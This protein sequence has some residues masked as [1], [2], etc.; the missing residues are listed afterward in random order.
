MRQIDTRTAAQRR[1]Y[2]AGYHMR[3]RLGAMAT[4]DARGVINGLAIRFDFMGDGEIRQHYLRDGSGLPM[5]PERY[6]THP[7]TMEQTFA[8]VR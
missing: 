3:R 5:W 7:E 8:R 1:D 2:M 6:R 4:V